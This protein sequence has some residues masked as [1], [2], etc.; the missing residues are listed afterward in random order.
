MMMAIARR[1]QSPEEGPSSSLLITGYRVGY[2]VVVRG[3]REGGVKRHRF[4][5]MIEEEHDQG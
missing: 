2:C 4:L 3:R 1:V 5:L